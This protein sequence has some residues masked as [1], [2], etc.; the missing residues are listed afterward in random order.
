MLNRFRQ[1]KGESKAALNP[2][3]LIC[4][5]AEPEQI[6]PRV[7]VG[8]SHQSGVK[9]HHLVLHYQR[10]RGSALLKK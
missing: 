7:A 6:K 5:N 3:N 2:D 4:T 9:I 10:A 1:I 8:M